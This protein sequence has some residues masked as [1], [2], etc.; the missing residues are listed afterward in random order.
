MTNKIEQ[1]I[2][3]STACCLLL[4]L[5]SC[6]SPRLFDST[7]KSATGFR[8]FMAQTAQAPNLRPGD[9]ITISIWG[10][11]DLSI[12]SINSSFTTDEG[13]GRWVVLDEEGE[14]NLPRVGRVK[15]S[16][17]NLKVAGY[18]LEEKYRV[19]IQDPVV[20][21]RVLNHFITILGEVNQPGK[22]RI[23]NEKVNLT[24]LMGQA[25]GFSKYADFHHIQ[26]IRQHNGMPLS[27]EVDFSRFESLAEKNAVLQPDDI[28]YIPPGGKKQSEEIINKAVPIA[29]I[30]TGL[31][32]VF[33][34]F[35]K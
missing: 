26:L 1:K 28:V 8:E 11:D 13:T 21:V 27:M 20:N 16:G 3:L 25:G 22:Y 6:Q 2:K 4:L 32:V 30:I 15:L 9:K 14:V 29:G 10:H 34:I 17:Y 18:F 33:S 7:A 35:K 23:D 24:G 12:G 31:A 5:V 19:H